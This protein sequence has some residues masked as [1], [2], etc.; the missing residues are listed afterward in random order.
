MSPGTVAKHFHQRFTPNHFGSYPSGQCGLRSW[1]LFTHSFVPYVFEVFLKPYCC[2]CSFSLTMGQGSTKRPQVDYVS[3]THL[4]SAL[5]SSLSPS[6]KETLPPPAAQGQ[7]FLLIWYL[8]LSLPYFW[9]QGIKSTLAR[10]V[11]CSPMGHLLCPKKMSPLG[12]NTSN[13]EESRPLLWPR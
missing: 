12:T 9:A 6:G 8:L 3:S 10:A 5:L 11:A 13:L 7:Q 4:S 1:D 2:R